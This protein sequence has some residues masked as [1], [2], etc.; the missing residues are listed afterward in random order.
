MMMDVL[1]ILGYSIDRV[2]FD[3]IYLKL[4]SPSAT[5]GAA[6]GWVMGGG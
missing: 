6:G 1:L 5:V 4:H 3:T 2:V